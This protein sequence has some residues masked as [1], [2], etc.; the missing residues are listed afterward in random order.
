MV[1]MQLLIRC[2]L[3]GQTRTVSKLVLTSQFGSHVTIWSFATSVLI[4][5]VPPTPPHLTSLAGAHRGGGGRQQVL[6]NGVCVC[7]LRAQ[8]ASPRS[9]SLLLLADAPSLGRSLPATFLLL[10]C[11]CMPLCP[12]T[13][14]QFSFTSIPSAFALMDVVLISLAGETYFILGPKKIPKR[15]AGHLERPNPIQYLTV[16]T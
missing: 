3:S 1:Q 13:N 8:S 10:C 6:R 7:S 11:S 14:S 4:V 2:F 16:Y 5:R 9:L 15:P 12:G